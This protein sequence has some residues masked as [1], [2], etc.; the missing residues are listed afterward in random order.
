[1]VHTVQCQADGY[2]KGARGLGQKVPTGKGQYVQAFMNL[3]NRFT[4]MFHSVNPDQKGVL[5]FCSDLEIRSY[6]KL[7]RIKKKIICKKNKINKISC[8]FTFTLPLPL[9]NMLYHQI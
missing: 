5:D 1:M 3:I 8:T 2:V 4:F 6:K 9:S 7:T